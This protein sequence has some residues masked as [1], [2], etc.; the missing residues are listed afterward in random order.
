MSN[1]TPV[2]TNLNRRRFLKLL[3]AV[4]GT[5][6]V[7]SALDSFG[8]GMASAQ[9]APP[10]LRG[11]RDGTRVIV[12]GAGVAGMTAAYE[13]QKLGYDTPILEARDFAGG[14]AQTARRGFTLTEA[15]GVTQRCRFDEGEYINH[16]PWRIPFHHRSVLHYAKQ[17]QVPLEIMVNQND[18]AY[19]LFE[20]VE[21][22]LS[23][24][25]LRQM[26]IKADMRGYT[27][28]LLAKAAQQDELDRELTQEDKEKLIEYLV[29]EGYLDS[30]DLAYRGMGARGYEEPP[31]AG[32]NPGVPSDPHGFLDLLRPEL[33]N[34]YRSV[35]S[36][37]QQPTMLQPVGGMDQIAKA[38][39]QQVGDDIH[40]GIEVTQIRQGEDGVRI[41]YRDTRTDEMGEMTGDYVVC[42]IPLSVLNGIDGDFSED[43]RQAMS[44][45]SYASTGKIGLQFARRFWEE[46]DWIYGG[47][48]ET[49]FFGSIS[50]PSYNF[51]KQKGVILGYYNFGGEAV[52][53]SNMTPEERTEFA[54]ENGEK[55][56]PGQYRDN[57]EESFS[58]AWHLVPYSLGGW[59][60]WSSDARENAYPLLNE[61][62]GRVYLAGE[63]LSYLTG[64]QAGGIESAWLQIEKLHRRAA[65]DEANAAMAAAGNA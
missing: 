20:D 3:G 2:P 23:G 1:E 65:Q 21:G 48:S 35:S 8:L 14:R 9:D 29:R 7:F 34:L 61:P 60:S 44:G 27:S 30:E 62:D 12:L 51:H 6:M 41:V 59:A 58:V 37:S 31:S 46:D 55:I 33:G 13:L 36:Y 47:H 57:F 16:G 43:F 40:Y 63:H 53:V 54:L 32:L 38:F 42:T 4:G 5:G 28:E 25:R 45:V 50:Y 19:A 22:P 10:D 49:N 15:N 64:W 39:E 52:R 26:E 17:F 18:A 11:R 24:Q 56:H